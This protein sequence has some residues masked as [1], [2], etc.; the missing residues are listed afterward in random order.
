MVVSN[1]FSQDVTNKTKADSNKVVWDAV[2]AKEGDLVGDTAIKKDCKAQW[3]W[4]VVKYSSEFSKDEKSANQIL[5][6][7]NVLPIGGESSN[8]WGVKVKSGKEAD[9]D[10]FIRV[11]YEKPA[12]I[13]QIAI[14]ESF[15]P[16]AITKVTIFG[17]EDGQ[18]K[19]VYE[20]T[21][22][23]ANVKS[24]MMNI[25]L[26]N[27]TEFYVKEVEIRLNPILV[28]GVNQID[29]IGIAECS[30][31]V[32]AKINVIPNIVYDNKP[33]NL[34]ENINSIYDEDAPMISPDGK[35]IYF[36]RKF[37][38]ENIGGYNDEDD[39]WYSVVDQNKKW[40]PAKNLGEPLNNKFNNFIQSITPD[41]NQLLLGNAYLKNNTMTEGVSMT[42]RTKT[43]WA[44][45][46]KQLIDGFVNYSPYAN[47]Y[48]TNDGKVMLMAIQMKDSYGGLDLYVSFRQ[49]E[50]RWTKPQNI[51]VGINTP[52]NDYSP[53]L[54]ADGV[55]L[56]FSTSGLP[57]YGAAD[58]YRVT[59]LD[60]TWEN[61]TEPQ[62]LGEPINTAGTDSKY[63]IPAS[64]EY[65]YY[66]TTNNSLG[67]KDIFRIALPKTVKP[68]PV[69]LITGVVR[70]DKTNQPVDARIIVEEL[71]G[72]E[73]VA[74]ARTD[75]RTGRFKI[76][77]PA[78]KKY[79]FRAVGLGFFDINKN[80][81]LT[82]VDEYTEIE[83]DAIRL[84]PIEVGQVVRLNNIFFETAKATLKSE[85]F[86]ELDRT[87]E[88]LENNPT[89][90]IE[91]AGH[92]D[93]VGS[94]L[95]NQRLSE[96]RAQSVASY[97]IEH[98]INTQRLVVHG[99]GESRPIAFNTDEDGRQKNRRVEFKVLKK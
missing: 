90:E 46:E 63:N 57:G 21:A 97:I 81:D 45:P 23:N 69:V 48:L 89:M 54:A 17:P 36:V 29:A 83:E 20:G 62:N 70:N 84:A 3:A 93:D 49:G 40:R 92:T 28:P 66:S 9:E 2:L 98:G 52:T 86:P 31:S 78:G 1:L 50:N 18:E 43:G 80:I 8:A 14:A 13:R 88:F 74:I 79:G 25:F 37:H 22:H 16:G 26:D 77:L 67:K 41:G 96:A 15:N 11:E 42:Y 65:A 53:F 82:D 38:P 7:P 75:P 76:I 51:G 91:I 64:G 94:D 35:T 55:T 44:F 12:L 68:N 56:Y 99:Y 24:R 87:V 5:G 59:R 85:S 72:G 39:I 19:V 30:D 58:I 60:D 6:Q 32:I 95:T 10:A 47:Y 4:K 27:V 73:E 33:E 61:W 71:P 34:S